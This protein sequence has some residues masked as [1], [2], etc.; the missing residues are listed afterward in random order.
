MGMSA[1]H[2]HK[3]KYSLVLLATLIH[4]IQCCKMCYDALKY[5]Q[6]TEMARHALYF[7][8]QSNFPE[9]GA[10]RSPCFY[11]RHSGSAQRI[12][13]HRHSIVSL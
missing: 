1:L 5:E 6:V 9:V 2:L 10:I 4:P 3:I 8:M 12:Q 13:V 11:S 7:E